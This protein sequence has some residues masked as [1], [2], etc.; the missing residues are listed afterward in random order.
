MVLLDPSVLI[1]NKIYNVETAALIVIVHALTLLDPGSE[2]LQNPGGG[3]IYTIH[4][5]KAPRGF[6]RHIWLLVYILY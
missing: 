2:R 5:V 1:Q 3:V 4:L 6:K